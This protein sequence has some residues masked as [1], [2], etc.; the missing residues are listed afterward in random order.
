MHLYVV[1]RGIADRL[2]RWEN[3]LLA[4]FYMFDWQKGQQPRALQ[5]GLRPIRFYEIVYPEPFHREVLETIYPYWNEKNWKMDA[6]KRILQKI[7][8]CGPIEDREKF[9]IKQN[10]KL[11]TDFVQC[12]AIGMKKDRYNEDGI[13]QL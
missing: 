7:L 12:T 10:M 2:N 1:A 6:G 8:N 11:Y 5:L 9:Q 3:D 13:E 4:K